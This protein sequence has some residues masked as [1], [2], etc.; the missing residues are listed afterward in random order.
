MGAPR[1]GGLLWGAVVFDSNGNAQVDQGDDPAAMAVAR[2]Q[3]PGG[4][5]VAITDVRG[6]YVLSPAAPGR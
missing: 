6:R 1:D 4:Q 5:A 3:G 2:I